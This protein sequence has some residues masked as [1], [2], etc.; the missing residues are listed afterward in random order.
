LT[1]NSTTLRPYALW[2]LP[3]AQRAFSLQ[4]E[5]NRLAES[6]GAASFEPHVT[7]YGGT[8]KDLDQTL[9]HFEQLQ[10]KPIGL[11][12][13]HFFQSERFTQTFGLR[14]K[15]SQSLTE[16]SRQ[17]ANHRAN[18]PDVYQLNPH[19]SLLYTQLEDTT[20]HQ[21]VQTQA[22]PEPYFHFNAI[23]IATPGPDHD[24]HKVDGWQIHA[25]RSLID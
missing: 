5:I 7:L 22:Q 17:M 6:Y 25:R 16:L 15:P 13:Q 4:Q 20:R 10:A 23:A 9:A 24:W 12:F 18:G 19:L 2:L 3:E 8:T 14:F 21:L 1:G 11:T